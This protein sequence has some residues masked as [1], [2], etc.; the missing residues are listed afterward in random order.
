MKRFLATTALVLTAC[1]GASGQ[2]AE[3]FAPT[4]HPRPTLVASAD[5]THQLDIRPLARKYVVDPTRSRFDLVGYG[6]LTGEAKGTFTSWHARVVMMDGVPKIE[7]DVLTD[8]LEVE[9]PGA[10]PILKKYFLETHRFPSAT[11]TGTLWRTNGPP[12]E[13]VVE[14][15][16]VVHGVRRGIRFTGSLTEGDGGYHFAARFVVSRKEF[17]VRFAPL[18]PFVR[19][20]ILIDIDVYAV[21]AVDDG[22]N[23][24]P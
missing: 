5:P 11:L 7:A 4:H 1:A 2:R 17:D 21:P 13:H 18:E 16:A 19:D 6:T 20:D 10:A 3:M 9:M 22:P 14:G 15:T 12:D 23:P 8:S 24:E